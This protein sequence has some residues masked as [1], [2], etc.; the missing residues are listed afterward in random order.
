MFVLYELAADRPA[1]LFPA[2]F[3]PSLVCSMQSIGKIVTR[4]SHSNSHNLVTGDENNNTTL[5]GKKSDLRL[6]TI[7]F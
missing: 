6:K 4:V 3:I 1:R 2:V 7:W 5:R